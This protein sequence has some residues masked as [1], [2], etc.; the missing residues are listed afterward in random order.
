MLSLIL[1]FVSVVQSPGMPVHKKVSM[2]MEGVTRFICTIKPLIVVKPSGKQSRQ[3]VAVLRPSYKDGK[4]WSYLYLHRK[5]YKRAA[6][7]CN[8]FHRRFKRVRAR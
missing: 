3:W 2:P 1:F 7:D 4:K 8:M 6:Q 5:R